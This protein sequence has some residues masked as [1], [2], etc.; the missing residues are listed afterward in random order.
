[1]ARE[2]SARGQLNSMAM[3]SWKTPKEARMAKPTSTTRLPAR[4]T[5]VM[6][7]ERWII[8]FLC[9][10]GDTLSTGGSA[11]PAMH[12]MT[13][14]RSQAFRHSAQMRSGQPRATLGLRYGLGPDDRHTL[15]L[16]SSVLVTVEIQAA[17]CTPFNPDL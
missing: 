12:R 7:G 15:P 17:C 14:R 5:G 16:N 2:N 9:A 3:G 13:R 10:K 6:R 4:R 1:M 11:R 8:P